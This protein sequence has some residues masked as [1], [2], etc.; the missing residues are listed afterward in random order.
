MADYQ[1]FQGLKSNLGVP[2]TYEL[3][4]H[5]LTVPVNLGENMVMH[6]TGKMTCLSCEAVIKKTFQNGYCY[7]CFREKASCDLCIVKP[8]LCH[9]H[10][11]T[12]REPEWGLAHCFKEH[13]VYLANSTGLKV[14][15]SRKVNIPQRWIDQGAKEACILLTCSNRLISGKVEVFLAQELSDRT[16]WQQLLKGVE[17]PVDM[18]VAHQKWQ[19][20]MKRH[21][22]DIGVSVEEIV[23][24][25][26]ELMQVEYPIDAYVSKA[27]SI[28]LAAGENV[29]G[30]LLGIKG[31]YL[32]FEE[33]GLNMR[34]LLGYQFIL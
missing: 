6:W 12:C 22:A 23:W 31:Q 16:K 30:I 10:L 17:T 19:N 20:H 14:G 18:K 1:V 28:K 4:F 34:N 5:Q 26:F 32:L 8:E 11:G 13:V 25:E 29:L 33:G 21:L 9:Y 2:V 3:K 7:R 27:K 15:I 24:N